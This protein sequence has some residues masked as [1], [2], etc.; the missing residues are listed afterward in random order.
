M[1][2]TYLNV[3]TIKYVGMTNDIFKR[4]RQH[5]GEVMGGARYKQEKNW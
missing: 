3:E 4:I 5:N 2:F 1:L